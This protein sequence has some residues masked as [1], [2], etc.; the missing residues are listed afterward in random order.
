MAKVIYGS[1]EYNIQANV[2]GKMRTLYIFKRSPKTLSTLSLTQKIVAQVPTD[3]VEKSVVS[4][5]LAKP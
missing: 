5:S 2:T 1:V 3:S 4:N